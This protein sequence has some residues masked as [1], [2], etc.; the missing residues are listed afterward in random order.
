[1]ADVVV[2]LGHANIELG[3]CG[4]LEAFAGA[5]WFPLVAAVEPVFARTAHAFH[6]LG[7]GRAE[8]QRGGQ[9][10]AH[11]LFGAVW[12]RKAVADAL[13]VK[14]HIGLGGEADAVNGFGGHEWNAKGVVR[15]K[16]AILGQRT[17]PKN[18]NAVAGVPDRVVCESAGAGGR[19]CPRGQFSP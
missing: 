4:N 6:D 8:G 16:P 7:G 13:A 19:R 5:G 18:K 2:S 12:Q 17:T 15:V 14:V 11:G 10:H 3:V 9:H 1:M